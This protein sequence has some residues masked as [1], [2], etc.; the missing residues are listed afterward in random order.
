MRQAET[1]Q[2]AGTQLRAVSGFRAVLLMAVMLSGPPLMSLTFSAIAPALPMI[3]EHFGNGTSGGTMIAQWI[4]TTPAIGLMLGGP[5]GGW[6]IDRVGP[7]RLIIA[8]LAGFALG[9][10]AGLWVET[11]AL[12]FAGRF[13]MGLSAATI[14]IAATWLIGERYEEHR[15]RRLIA[16][17]DTIAGIT[18]MGAVLLAGF[19]AQ[20]G[21]WRT[22]FA[23]YLIAVPLLFA[24]VAS[25]PTISRTKASGVSEITGQSL[26]KALMPHW[27]IY[28]VIVAMAGLMMM[29]A[30]QV[31]FLLQ[32]S[33]V[34]DPVVRSRVIAC[35][36]LLAIVGAALF[37]LLRSRLGEGGTFRVI[38]LAYLLGTATLSLAG[39]ALQAALGCAC[40]GIGTGLFGPF[41]ASLLISR[42]SS[43]V[44]G[45]ALGFMFGAIFLSE[46]LSPL[47]ILPLRH[48]FGVHGGF[49][50]L[51]CLLAAGL[52]AT[53]LR[54]PFKLEVSQAGV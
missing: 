27:R 36:A 5:S 24:A 49:G 37:P 16:A 23:I 52:V 22:P 32:A 33:G 19:A 35:S 51:A 21:S 41:F 43:E 40:M 31:P 17:Q 7:R 13:L 9:G 20:A 4:M 1:A 18:A 54:S 53:I 2:A 14:A 50:A 15:R 3:A 48:A 25:V 38:V 12:L 11:P 10:S 26:A 45:R 46:F 47:V 44:R 28:A 6:L 34:E 29:P 30:T 39:N 42:T 8:A